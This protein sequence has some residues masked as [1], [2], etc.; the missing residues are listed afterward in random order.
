MPT[1]STI[2]GSLETLSITRA[3]GFF[4]Y[5]VSPKM[6][7]QRPIN[8][9]TQR[10][11]VS[12]SETV[13]LS[14]EAEKAHDK[15]DGNFDLTYSKVIRRATMCS[16]EETYETPTAVRLPLAL[17]VIMVDLNKIGLHNNYF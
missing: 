16:L 12:T 8:S 9:I 1:S 11:K 7:G 14:E 6:R 4:H 15:H 3:S 13:I 10:E 5:D 2:G 17:H